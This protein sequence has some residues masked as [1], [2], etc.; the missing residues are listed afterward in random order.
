MAAAY[1]LCTKAM[2]YLLMTMLTL[3]TVASLQPVGVILVVAM[4]II[5]ASAAYLLTGRPSRMLVLSAAL[6]VF[7]AVAGLS[8]RY[9]HALPSGP[10]IALA[11]ACVFPLSFVLAPRHGLIRRLWTPRGPRTTPTPSPPT[12]SA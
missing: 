4:L 2:Y 6:G 10:V 12:P 9:R 11:A 8:F 3:V 1:G 7:S 5:P